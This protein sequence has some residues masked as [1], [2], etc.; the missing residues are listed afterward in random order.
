MLHVLMGLH[1]LFPSVPG[2]L[3]D[4]K[5]T[6]RFLG[7]TMLSPRTKDQSSEDELRNAKSEMLVPDKHFWPLQGADQHSAPESQAG[8][9]LWVQDIEREGGRCRPPLD[10]AYPQKPMCDGI[11]SVSPLHPPIIHSFRVPH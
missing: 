2:S 5:Q 11:F 6:H 1:R 7:E 4:G 3:M 9:V 8:L 10:S